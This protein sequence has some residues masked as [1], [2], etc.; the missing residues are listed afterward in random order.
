MVESRRGVWVLG[1]HEHA[2]RYLV[3]CWESGP[4]HVGGGDEEPLR[5]VAVRL[6]ICSR[7]KHG[8]GEKNQACRVI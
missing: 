3:V 6:E 5:Q 1:T 2:A 4:T 8:K 7:G